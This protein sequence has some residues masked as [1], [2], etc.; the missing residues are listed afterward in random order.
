MLDDSRPAV[1]HRA[2]ETVAADDD[3]AIAL[4]YQGFGA[5]R[6]LNGRRNA[7]W[8]AARIEHP[9]ARGMIAAGLVDP[10]ETVRQVAIHAVSVR[11]D[12]EA[13]PALLL[14]LHNPSLHNRRAAA[15][16]LGR[17]GDHSAVP[18]LLKALGE[19]S[20]PDRV[21]EHSLTYALIEIADPRA[22]AEGLSSTNARSRRAAL[23]ALDQ[24]NGGGL[25]PLRVA[26]LLTSNDS[27]LRETASW[28]IGRHREWAGALS[29]FLRDRLSK[30]KLAAADQA[31]LERQLA[32]FAAAPAIQSLLAERLVDP[33]TLTPVKLSCLRAMAQSGLK[34]VPASWIE[35]LAGC[36]NNDGS[37]LST[38][39][40]ATSRA[41]PLTKAHAGALTSRL[42][43]LAGRTQAPASL[44][45]AALA[46][47]PGGLSRVEPSLF[48]Y[49]M[50]QLDREQPA[51][52]RTTAA[53]VLARARLAR[54]AT[55]EPGGC[56]QERRSAR[57]RSAAD[58][59][60]AID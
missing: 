18:E 58:G 36:L 35:G 6:S 44:R 43:A 5:N 1:Q 31:E 45:L 26:G 59:P 25:D 52:A 20:A 49:L 48:S 47:V 55:G 60:R 42:L 27:E 40:V 28:I 8:A 21:L 11:R 24:M 39:A 14:L 10:D 30:G 9:A 34:E 12:P 22:T 3:D 53:D 51:A 32:R 38:Q 2:I 37:D 23:F 16:A 54:C 7:I 41:L 50:G 15:E 19:P 4:S 56:P 33:S 57:N 29:G 13:V 17:I 46:A